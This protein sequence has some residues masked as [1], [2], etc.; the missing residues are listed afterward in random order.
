VRGAGL[1]SQV[2]G[3]RTRGN[4]LKVHQ[5]RFRLDIRKSFFTKR[6]VKHWPRLPRAVGESPSL[7]VFKRRVDL[8]LGSV[9]GLAVLG[10]QLDSMILEVFSN[11]NDSAKLVVAQRAQP[12]CPRGLNPPEKAAFWAGAEAWGA[13]FV[14]KGIGALLHGGFVASSTL[15]PFPSTQSHPD[16]PR[17]GGELTGGTPGC[18]SPHR[19]FS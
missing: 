7:E 14:C 15:Q 13:G 5:G 3:D 12:R 10:L 11:L 19:A 18:A 2:T 9:V 16:N 17:G 4:G 1:F 8:A 6:V